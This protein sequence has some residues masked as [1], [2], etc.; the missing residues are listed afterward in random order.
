MPTLQQLWIYPI[1]SLAGISLTEAKL[2]RRGLAHD[3]R[4]MLIDAAGQ[5]LTQ[6]ELPGMALLDQSLEAE[7]LVV[8]HRQKTEL[9]ALKLSLQPKPGEWIEVV[10]WDDTCTAH[11]VDAAADEWFSQALGF[12]CRLVYMPESSQRVVDQR[13]AQTNDITSFSDGFPYLLANLNSLADLNQRL[14]QAVGIERF[15]PN[16]VIDGLEAWSEDG[17]KSFKLGEAHFHST[18]PCARCQVITID[19]QTAS[20][21]KE[22]LKTLA[23]F[24]T[25]NNKVFFGLNACWDFE[26]DKKTLILRVGDA[27]KLDVEE[28]V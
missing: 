15:R 22:P 6:R 25:W 14:A 16:L 11:F 9:G 17:L 13:Y 12:K 10:V 3:R 23:T 7:N 5:F 21:G 19:P 28:R 24:H 1:K 27:L 2:T 4:W 20:S 8:K 18:K 26:K